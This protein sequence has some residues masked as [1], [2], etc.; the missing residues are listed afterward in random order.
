[1]GRKEFE[2]TQHDNPYKVDAL[3][4]VVFLAMGNDDDADDVQVVKGDWLINH[5]FA[6]F[7]PPAIFHKRSF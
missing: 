3:W 1:M 7:K 6:V 2:L 4:M 5:T